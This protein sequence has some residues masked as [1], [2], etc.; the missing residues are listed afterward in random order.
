MGQDLGERLAT[1]TAP[2]LLAKHE[3][4]LLFT[5]EGFEDAVAAF[6]GAR[7]VTCGEKPSTSADF[8]PVLR[9][10]CAQLVGAAR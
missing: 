2:M 6:P 4:C 8:V 1:L 7:V 3:G 10:F 9:E 5:D